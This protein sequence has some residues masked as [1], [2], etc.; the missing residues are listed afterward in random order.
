[1]E[2][3]YSKLRSLFDE[4]SEFFREVQRET[5]EQIEQKSRCVSKLTRKG[6]P[7][8][9]GNSS[10]P[11]VLGTFLDTVKN[12]VL[13]NLTRD[14]FKTKKEGYCPGCGEWCKRFERAHTIKERPDIAKEALD[15]VMAKHQ[16]EGSFEMSEFLSGFIQLHRK[17]PITSICTACHLIFDKI[18]RKEIPRGHLTYEQLRKLDYTAAKPI[19]I[20][21]EGDGF[22]GDKYT[23]VPK[24]ISDLRYVIFQG[25]A[26][27][28]LRTAFTSVKVSPTPKQRAI[29]TWTRHE[30]MGWYDKEEYDTEGAMIDIFIRETSDN[31]SMKEVLK[32]IF[33]ERFIKYRE[34]YMHTLFQFGITIKLKLASGEIVEITNKMQ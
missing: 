26:T 1:M 25:V 33:E 21:I 18:I 2:A 4:K 20:L 9:F 27:Q 13:T 3:R 23:D 6:F 22:Y 5:E 31:V 11:F 29:S 16:E 28:Y 30:F 8:V 34:P 7:V 15:S 19:D 14:F 12:S 32:A 10:K 17:Y 24:S